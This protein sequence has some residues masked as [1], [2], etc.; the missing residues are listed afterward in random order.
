VCQPDPAHP[1]SQGGARLSVHG[2]GSKEG[3]K[4]SESQGGPLVLEGQVYM[5]CRGDC[6]EKILNEFDVLGPLNT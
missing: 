3:E 4:V 1:D 5:G 2:E 6:V